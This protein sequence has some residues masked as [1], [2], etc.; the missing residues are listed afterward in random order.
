VPARRARRLTGTLVVVLALVAVGAVLLAIGVG[1]GGS[2]ASHYGQLPAWLPKAKVA[3]GR[4]VRAT[5]AHPRL[6]IQGDTVSVA[7]LH[8]SV[9]ATT[10]GPTVPE[11]GQFPVPKTSP[12]TFTVTL[13]AAAGSVP[14]AP[15]AFTILDELGHVHHPHVRLA[16]GGALPA[17]VQAG[18]TVTLTVQDVLPTGGGRLR[19]APESA[20]PIASWDFDVE[21]D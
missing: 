11:D 4:V 13:R 20:R 8:G 16:Q 17:R 1:G 15:R 18:R 9:L 6:A 3:T 14:L 21:I 12:T 2:T 5:S 10:V 19:W 7:L